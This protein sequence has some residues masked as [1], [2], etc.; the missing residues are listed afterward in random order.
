MPPAPRLLARV[1]AC[2]ALVP[3]LAAAAP[4][5]IVTSIPPYAMAARSVAGGEGEVRVLVER[6]KDPH[7]FEPSIADIAH[8]QEADLVIRNGLG[9][10]Q[11]EDHLGRTARS[12]QLLT[13][14]ETVPYEP[15]R[16]Q[17][18]AVNG[19]I[20]LNPEVM[21]RVAQ[22][23]AERLGELRPERAA[24]FAANAEQFVADIRA[25]DEEARE[26]LADLPTRR[27]VTYHPAFEYFFRH[28]DMEVA[29]TY[30]DLAGNEPSPKRV[31]ELL[32]TIREED[33]PAI[34]R[35]PQLPKA[36]V[37][38]LADEA[39]I[40]VGVLDP[41]GFEGDIQ[42]YPDLLRYNARQVR[43]AYDG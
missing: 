24:A 4:L 6:G 33:I 22:A 35:E 12:E 29:G 26:L 11:V 23:L 31:R 32:D 15:V 7:H 5:E 18:G 30:L 38:A 36:P 21:V 34:F 28:Y 42:A 3:A 1:L 39:G 41:L 9:L 43:D 13:V 10:Q 20:W 8:V 37:Q 14:S 16:D 40:A 17:R 2:L 27:V 25:A 19:H